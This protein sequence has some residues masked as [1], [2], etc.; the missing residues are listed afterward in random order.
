MPLCVGY[1]VH[2]V[3]KMLETEIHFLSTTFFGGDLDE[4]IGW[5]L[6]VETTQAGFCFV[7]VCL[8]F[9]FVF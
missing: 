1:C 9:V 8:F 6:D 5:Y 7:F 4:L 2:S 3:T